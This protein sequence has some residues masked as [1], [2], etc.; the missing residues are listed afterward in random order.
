MIRQIEDFNG[1]GLMKAAR[2]SDGFFYVYPLPILK[3][4]L[5]KPRR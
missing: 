2:P 1:Y 5:R 3:E 4:N